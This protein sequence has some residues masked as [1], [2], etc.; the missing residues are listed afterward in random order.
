MLAVRRARVA[1]T[2]GGGHFGGGHLGQVAFGGF[3]H[4]VLGGH[5]GVGNFGQYT[6]GGF[7]HRGHFGHEIV[8][9]GFSSFC[10][11]KK[12]KTLPIMM[13]IN[14]IMMDRSSII[15]NLRNI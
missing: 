9:G 13:S 1:R 11:T 2:F 6:L 3:G 15:I 4:F 10:F 14:N 7:G 5:V 12:N 8:G